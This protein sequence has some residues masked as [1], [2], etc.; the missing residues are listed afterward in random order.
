MRDVD[1][2]G[3]MWEITLQD[4]NGEFGEW[5]SI[6]RTDGEYGKRCGVKYD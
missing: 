2:E 5:H 4:L 1:D 6:T 3:S